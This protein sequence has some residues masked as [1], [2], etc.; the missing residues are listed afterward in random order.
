MVKCEI[1]PSVSDYTKE[2]SDTIIVKSNLGGDIP[3][4]YEM[5]LLRK[6]SELSSELY[7]KIELLETCIS[8]LKNVKVL[9]KYII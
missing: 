3:T 9:T 4:E 8:E 1:L 6:L 7:N 2:L 5:S